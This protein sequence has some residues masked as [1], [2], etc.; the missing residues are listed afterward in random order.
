MSLH[1]RGVCAAAMPDRLAEVP[2]RLAEDRSANCHHG[3]DWLIAANHSKSED[4]AATGGCLTHLLGHNNGANKV[5]MMYL[6]Y[7]PFCASKPV[8]V[9]QLTLCLWGQSRTGVSRCQCVSL[10][11]SMYQKILVS[12]S[13]FQYT[14]VSAAR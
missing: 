5:Y 14:A 10:Y 7:F 12:S 3:C 6:Y 2:D 9:Q 11:V 13:I 1:S 8:L 4:E